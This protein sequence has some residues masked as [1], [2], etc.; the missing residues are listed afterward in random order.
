MAAI[1]VICSLTHDGETT[2]SLSLN[3]S[4]EAIEAE[5]SALPNVVVESVSAKTQQHHGPSWLVTFAEAEENLPTL[6]SEFDF[7][8]GNG[9]V[10]VDEIVDGEHAIGGIF[11]LSFRG[12]AT[13]ALAHDASADEVYDALLEILVLNVEVTHSDLGDKRGF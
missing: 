5:L 10:T 1:P 13:V 6:S 2:G 11:A 4:A 7:T 3:A 9:R 8:T 12:R